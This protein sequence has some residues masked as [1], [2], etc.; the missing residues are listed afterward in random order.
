MR[1]SDWS[2]DVCSSDLEA[3]VSDGVII[4]VDMVIKPEFSE[5]V[6][7]G[8]PAM[9][10]DTARF[11]GLRSIR[12]VQHPHDPH[13]VLIVEHWDCECDYKTYSAW[14][15]RHGALSTPLALRP[16]TRMDGWRI[17]LTAWTDNEC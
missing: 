13:H 7:S 8:I 10:K 6:R 2:S 11:K 5:A 15:D 16:T 3:A 17:G 14:P 12:V 4:T 1:M 9:L